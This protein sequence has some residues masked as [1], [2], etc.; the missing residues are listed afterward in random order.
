MAKIFE[1]D[2]TSNWETLSHVLKILS[3][4][5]QDE[6]YIIERIFC[7]DLLKFVIEILLRNSLER[8]YVFDCISFIG[9]CL[10]SADD[11][12][13]VSLLYLN[14]FVPKDNFILS[15]WLEYN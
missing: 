12:T 2:Y 6:K 14:F 15:L 10:T 8:E 5:S 13:D 11:V 4:L 3:F 9:N 1:K 7:F